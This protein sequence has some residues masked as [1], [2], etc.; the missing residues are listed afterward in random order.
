MVKTELK[1][2][3]LSDAEISVYMCLLQN[4]PLKVSD[5]SK[6][7]GM[8]R[9]YVYDN[10]YKLIEKGMCGNINMDGKKVFR[11]AN[12]QTIRDFLAD[13]MRRIDN[14]IPELENMMLKTPQDTSVWVYKGRNAARKAFADI[15]KI[16]KEDRS[17]E[18]LGMGVMEE[19]FLLNEPTFSRWFIKQ[20]E[21]YKIKERMISYESESVFAGGKTTEYRFIPDE[22]FNPTN[23]MIDGDLVTII[24]WKNPKYVIKIKSADLAD[25]YR[26]QFELM[27]KHGK[28]KHWKSTPHSKDRSITPALSYV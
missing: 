6:K 23:T 10:L 7:I 13:K 1:E 8:Y 25:S 17:I 3:G 16:L 22:Y 2:A 19:L 21:K 12:P 15:L 28:K 26:K 20:L 27:W 14:A 11:A 18:H 9:P 4:G 5:I 24:F